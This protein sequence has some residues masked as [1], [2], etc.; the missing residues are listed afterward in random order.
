MLLFHRCNALQAH[1]MIRTA[2]NYL[3]PAVYAG[4]IVLSFVFAN[5]IDPFTLAWLLSLTVTADGIV[6]FLAASVRSKT[7]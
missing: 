4:F 1:E 2:P 7:D 3:L 5:L 6:R